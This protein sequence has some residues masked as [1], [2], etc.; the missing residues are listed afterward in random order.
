V[1]VASDYEKSK[2]KKKP[3]VKKIIGFVSVVGLI[4]TGFFFVSTFPGMMFTPYTR[5]DSTGWADIKVH[6]IALNGSVIELNEGF[7]VDLFYASNGSLY[8]E[9]L[10]LSAF[11]IHAS[12][13]L[14]FMINSTMNE[15]QYKYSML[16]GNEDP[17]Q[18][19]VNEVFLK[20][21]V[22]KTYI[23]VNAFIMNF[24]YD[25]YFN[26]EFLDPHVSVFGL[27]KNDSNPTEFLFGTFSPQLV[28]NVSGIPLGY[29]WGASTIIPPCVF[30][31]EKDR[32]PIA[33]MNGYNHIGLHLAFDVEVNLTILVHG[34]EI[35]DFFIPIEA[36]EVN[37]TTGIDPEK[38]WVANL[39]EIDIN[40]QVRFVFE[41]QDHFEN[42][43]LWSGHLDQYNS[44]FWYNY[45]QKIEV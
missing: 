23:S 38:L 32:F 44:S 33:N 10:Q 18:P 2:E 39:P 29:T 40:Q 26:P 22:P 30:D 17:S 4:V 36:R 25:N 42:I 35:S 16:F 31:Q 11:P 9:G 37:L 27:G 21:E 3:T 12:I 6:A 15:Y 14:T 24:T 41:T 13:P 19:Y 43:F 28:F 7:Q 34:S 1:R 20:R 45:Y 5:E 8:Q